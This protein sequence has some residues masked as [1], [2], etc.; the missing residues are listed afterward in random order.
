MDGDREHAMMKQI[1]K[2]QVWALSVGMILPLGATAQ[3]APTTTPQIARYEVGYAVPPTVPGRTTVPLT[4]DDAIARALENN[5][6]IQSA[7][8]T[9]RMQEYSLVSARAAFNPTF[10]AT[11]GYN[12]SS[13]QSTSQLDGG[14]RT[15]TSRNT[16]NLSVNQPLPWYG[17]SLSTSF[18]NSRSESDNAF[19][20]R[21]PSYSSSFSLNFSQPLLNGF[22][23]DNQRLS[24][25]TQVIQQE[26]A[27]IT[28]TAQVANIT[29]QVRVA[30]WNLRSQ[31]EQVEIQRF[32]L[33]QAEQLLVNNRLRV[34]TGT[35]ASNEL[36]Q[37]EAQVA[38]AEQALLNAE[39]QWRNQ[40]LTFKRLLVSGSTD[41][42]FEQTINPVDLPTFEE[43]AVDIEEAIEVALA[44]RTDIRQQ[45]FQQEISEMNLAVTRESTLP[46]LSLSASYSLQGVGGN[47]YERTG[48]GGEPVLVAEGGWTQGLSAIRNF[49]TPSFNVS[50]NFSYPLGMKSA[51]ANYQRAILQFQQSEIA[52]QGQELAITTE[53]TAA[54]DAVRNSFLSLQAAIRSREA[55]ERNTE[56]E[57]T[58]FGVGASTNFQVVTAQNSLTTSRLSELRAVI[59]YV[60][61]IAEF[62]RVVNVGR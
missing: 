11:V 61:A 31:I 26:V 46:N 10:Q 33:E 43:V 49:D 14:A 30:Y 41:P 7:R 53:V 13:N 16:F 20:T 58:R 24:L 19:T 34:E 55:S 44:S 18:N 60:N 29:N 1:R 3:Q 47:L 9:P 23:I 5:L 12:N 32:N 38:T 17:A 48:L 35:M 37:A 39:I 42:L 27:D 54:G 36:L 51:K 22:R 50:L 62:D 4:L 25:V 8:L 59:A 56:A 15:T 21:N 45:R 2:F 52:L 6:D 28:L 57:M 40:E